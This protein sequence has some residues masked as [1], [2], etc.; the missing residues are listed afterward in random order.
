MEKSAPRG[1]E[2]IDFRGVLWRAKNHFLGVIF[3]DNFHFLD[4]IFDFF[5][6]FLIFRHFAKETRFFRFSGGMGEF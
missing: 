3:Y 5:T 6:K 2:K 4:I 1:G